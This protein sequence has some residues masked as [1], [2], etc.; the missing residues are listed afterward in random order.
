M[1]DVPMASSDNFLDGPSIFNGKCGQ[2]TQMPNK[3]PASGAVN[4]GK[5]ASC[6]LKLTPRL[7]RK[8][9]NSLQSTALDGATENTYRRERKATL[10]HDTAPHVGM[11]ILETAS[12]F[13]LGVPASQLWG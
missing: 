2:F 11:L 4:G 6:N 3:I 9:D 1:I 5:P 13:V 10:E 12:A 7:I 8:L